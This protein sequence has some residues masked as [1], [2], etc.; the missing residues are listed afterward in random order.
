[1]SSGLLDPLSFRDPLALD[2]LIGILASPESEVT[3]GAVDEIAMTDV[4]DPGLEPIDLEETSRSLSA[5][6]QIAANVDRKSAKERGKVDALVIQQVHEPLAGLT[7][8]AAASPGFWSWLACGPGREF[9]WM[10]WTHLSPLPAGADE[11]ESEVTR[12]GSAIDGRFRLKSP[13]LNG[14]SRHAL[15]R[16]WWIAD[17]LESDYESCRKI[18]MNQDIFQAIYERDI[19]FVPGLANELINVFELG[20]QRGPNGDTFR[21]IMKAINQLA[22]VTRIEALRTS[23]LHDLVMQV[24][25]ERLVQP[26]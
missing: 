11:V 7:R 13:S 22:S 15:A 2:Q 16:L 20:T 23:D 8:Q 17:G 6:A 1:M 21:E 24:K 9:V 14:V 19:G 10:R 12:P 3:R 4:F 18:L 5:A 26:G 25:R